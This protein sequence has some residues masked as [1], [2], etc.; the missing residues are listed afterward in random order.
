[1]TIERS[2][3]TS[4]E[5]HYAVTRPKYLGMSEVPA[6]AG[7]D[8]FTTPLGLYNQR[9]GLVP[10][11]PPNQKMLRGIIMEYAAIAALKIQFPDWNVEHAD[12]YYHDDERRIACT[13]DGILTDPDGLTVNA[14]IKTVGRFGYE[15]FWAAGPPPGVLLQTTGEGMMLD[16]DRSFAVA[17]IPE[18]GELHLHDVPRH[19]KREAFVLS[20]AEEFWRRIDELDPPPAEFTRDHDEI[21]ALYPQSV[22]ETVLDLSGNNRLPILLEERTLLKNHIAD[23]ERLVKT[24]D[25]EI[26][27]RMKE[28]EVAE[29]PG[30][31]ITW[32]TQ[33]RPEHVVKE[34]TSR[35][36]LVKHL[37]E[38]T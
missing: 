38:Q 35:P 8:P 29:L 6:A 3:I 10:A 19:A 37:E 33:I 27:A 24:I 18:T 11:T 23:S 13:P 28:A 16:A 15:K 21:A 26:K 1:M 7:I 4:R 25:T 17:F 34:T 32:K 30:W 20:T 12:C 36:L 31:R 22:P 5:I 14:Q 2:P 9:L